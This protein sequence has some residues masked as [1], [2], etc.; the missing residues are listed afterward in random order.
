MQGRA[1]KLVILFDTQAKSGSFSFQILSVVTTLFFPQIRKDAGL[2]CGPRL[3]K[4]GVFA[5]VGS[6]QNLKDLKGK[7]TAFD[8]R[9]RTQGHVGSLGRG[10]P[11]SVPS[12]QLHPLRHGGWGAQALPRL[13][14]S[15]VLRS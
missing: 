13:Q 6:I 2:C 12:D 7:R 3:R 14:A 4:G 1:S 5:F 11:E 8:R 9:G 10:D 15:M